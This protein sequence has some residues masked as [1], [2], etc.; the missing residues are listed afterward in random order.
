M[1]LVGGLEHLFFS[2]IFGIIIPM[3]EY[4]S[5]GWLNHQ[6]G[7][8]SEEDFPNDYFVVPSSMSRLRP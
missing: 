2:H 8:D 6:P 1:Y 7:I 3:D 5:E 4:F